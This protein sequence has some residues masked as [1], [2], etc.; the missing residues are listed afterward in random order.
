M[1]KSSLS[2]T[3]S[4]LFPYE[5]AQS[6]N[7]KSVSI[8]ED[9]TWSP[10]IQGTLTVPYSDKLTK[11]DPRSS[12]IYILVQLQQAWGRSDTF[13]ELKADW[14][15]LYTFADLA[16]YWGTKTFANLRSDWW[17]PYQ[18]PEPGILTR[19]YTLLVRSVSIDYLN[20]EISMN[21][22]SE[23]AL[24][25][26]S[27]WIYAP[28]SPSGVSTVTPAG[29]SIVPIV[30]E[31]LGW[32]GRTLSVFSSSYYDIVRTADQRKIVAGK[33]YFDYLQDLLGNKRVFA[34]SDG[35]WWLAEDIYTST[36]VTGIPIPSITLDKD[37]NLINAEQSIDRDSTDW[38]NAAVITWR[39]TSTNP[40]T[41]TLDVYQTA[42]TP[43]K[44][45]TETI[46]Q[47]YPGYS[48]ARKR[49]VAAQERSRFVKATAVI[50]LNTYPSSDA[51]IITPIRTINANVKA[52]TFRLPADEMDIVANENQIL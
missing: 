50:D 43:L 16:T 17:T 14:S 52:V 21:V 23:D 19:K 27:A 6:L 45:Y 15:P 22:A 7:V 3:A 33:T 24:L 25:H 48:V 38:Y 44:V 49:L 46:E 40:V 28:Y 29:G 2:A 10:R 31:V 13:S 32:I 9:M 41:E 11:L 20:A 5:W 30:Q 1:T 47:P 42:Y 51:T 36:A 8:T 35:I 26:D 12:E 34:D 18:T 37:V 4:I 39:D